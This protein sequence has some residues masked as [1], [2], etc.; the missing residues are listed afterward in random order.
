VTF[1]PNAILGA[2]EDARVKYVLVGGLAAVAHGSPL[3]TSDVDIVP[4]RDAENLDRLA[5]ALRELGARLRTDDGPV[6]FPVDGAF[7]AAMPLM[8][9]L[10]TDFGVLDITYEPAGPRRGYDEWNADATDVDIGVGLTI[11][12]ASLDAVI[13]SKQAADRP[14]DHRSLPYLESLREQIQQGY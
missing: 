13:E 6:D 8:V 4:S 10:V 7:L 2:L 5:S 3:P 12:V 14:K 1:D 11:R 9:N